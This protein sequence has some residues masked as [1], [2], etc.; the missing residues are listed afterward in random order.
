MLALVMTSQF[1]REYLGPYLCDQQ[2]QKYSCRLYQESLLR[3][4]SIQNIQKVDDNCY[5]SVSSNISHNNK[6]ENQLNS[7]NLVNTDD[8]FNTLMNK[9]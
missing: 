4:L 5:K 3:H 7:R 9:L 2:P 1:K 8:Q 6:K